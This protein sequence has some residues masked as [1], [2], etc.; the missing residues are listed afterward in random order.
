MKAIE[1]EFDGYK[2]RSRL[3]ARWAVF[4]KTLGIPYA[5]EK[6]GFDLEGTWYLPDFWL[7]EQQYWIE[8]K[9]QDPTEEEHRKC[10]LLAK[11]LNADKSNVFLLAGEIPHPHFQNSYSEFFMYLR[12]STSSLGWSHL[13]KGRSTQSGAISWQECPFC[14]KIDLIE[15]LLEIS[16]ECGRK[17]VCQLQDLS[18]PS[19][20]QHEDLFMP[21]IK[22]EEMLLYWG[23]TPRLIDAYTTARQARFDHR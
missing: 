11:S 10:A 7:P 16:C 13:S 18:H 17:F 5:Y 9:G 23:D 3:E 15:D 8:V 1:T 6:E 2:F 21:W 19:W 14:R 20:S 12:D 22:K 4:F